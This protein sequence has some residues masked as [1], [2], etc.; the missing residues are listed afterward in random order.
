M[1]LA[2]AARWDDVEVASLAHDTLPSL[3]ETASAQSSLRPAQAA[4]LTLFL[5]DAGKLMADLVGR[6]APAAG[7]GHAFVEEAA[8][9]ILVHGGQH[10]NL[11]RHVMRNGIA[12]PWSDALT[13]QERFLSDLPSS[14]LRASD[15]REDPKSESEVLYGH[16]WDP[17]V[18]KDT[19]LLGDHISELLETVKPFERYRLANDVFKSARQAVVLRDRRA[20]LDALARLVIPRC[21]DEVVGGLL[22]AIDAWQKG[23]AVQAWCR[24]TLPDVIVDRFPTMARYITSGDD[25]LTRALSR[26]RLSD[27]ERAAIM[28]DGIQRHVDVL[29]SERILRLAALVG[30]TLSEADAASLVD[31]YIER[32]VRRLPVEHRDVDAYFD[33][34]RTVEEAMARFL[35]AY[36]GDC[37]V[38]NRWRAAHAARRLARLGDE[39]TLHALVETYG[40]TQDRAFRASGVPFYWL[41][42][43]LWFAL[44]WDRIALER[45]KIAGVAGQTLFRIATSQALPHLILRSIAR[46]G[47]RKLLSAG[48]LSLKPAQH[49]RLDAVNESPLP[50]ATVTSSDQMRRRGFG[51]GNRFRFDETDT[52]RYWYDNVFRSF[53]SVDGHRFIDEAERWIV[54]VW[55][56][57]EDDARREERGNVRERLNQNWELTM[58][59]HG[60][61]PTMER[62]ST[63]LEWHA[64]WCTAGEL[65]KTEPLGDSTEDPFVG[66]LAACIARET[67]TQPPLWSADLRGPWPLQKRYWLAETSTISR[68]EWVE[69][70]SESDLRAEVF[71]ED[72]ADYVIV[73]GSISRRF[74]DRR[75]TTEVN[76]ALVGRE[77][78]RVLLRTL[79]TMGDSWD[80]GLPAQGDCRFEIDEPPFCLVGWLHRHEGDGRIDE[81]D[82]FR[83]NPLRVVSS[84]GSLVTTGLQPAVDG[85]PSWSSR[86]SEQP[87]FN[88]QTWGGRDS[89]DGSSFSVGGYR[90]LAHRAQLLDFLGATA[91]DLIVGC[92]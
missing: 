9:D 57:T 27:I 58:N 4:A 24:D 5:D 73:D 10:K 23:S 3:V 53:A 49:A 71:P 15:G 60:A 8:R 2:N 88:Y 40:R 87:M 47:C 51:Q 59:G 62:L 80:Y 52:L 63:Y 61:R 84:P 33:T 78:A 92:R 13:R 76:T 81:K 70:V 50:A 56:Y 21:D 44:A 6:E 69:G 86:G 46:D 17:V 42:A 89:N 41:A 32:S 82:P 7:F 83:S 16:V 12:G 55:G 38:R 91:L 65:T 31:W 26:T 19:A 74:A 54:D 30:C 34:P 28:L 75:H 36:M 29:G 45:P 20:H 35:F 48:Q 39:T 1:A 22:E 79:Q 14:T 43:N 37:D 66:D 68:T 11:A 18:L 85:H 67:L 90:L 64:L 77:R 25:S 72:A